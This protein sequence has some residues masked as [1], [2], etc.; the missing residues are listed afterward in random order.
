MKITEAE[1]TELAW[2]KTYNMLDEK[3]KNGTLKEADAITAIQFAEETYGK[4]IDEGLTDIEL[5][6][7]RMLPP[8][9]IW[10]ENKPAEVKIE[11]PKMI[12]KKK[13]FWNKLIELF[14]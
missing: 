6:L 3:Y 1:A 7:L 8:T 13:S 12:V 11:L 14:K 2:R 10:D 5:D 9:K 4:I